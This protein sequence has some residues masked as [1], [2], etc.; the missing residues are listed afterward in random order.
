MEAYVFGVG[1]KPCLE[2]WRDDL[3]ACYLPVIRRKGGKKPNKMI[4]FG[5]GEVKLFKLFFPEDQL[6]NVMGLIGADEGYVEKYSVVKSKIKWLRRLLKLKETPKPTKIYPH[7]QPNQINKAVAI[8][9]IGTRKD[10]FGE[11]GLECI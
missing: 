3:Q 4:R 2:Q 5:V 10:H 8:I 7:M 1:T 9:P 6:D 11:D